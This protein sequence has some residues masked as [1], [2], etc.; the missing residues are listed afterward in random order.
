MANPDG[1]MADGSKRFKLNGGRADG[2]TVR[3]FP[4]NDGWDVL[5][6]YGETYLAPS[7]NDMK[8]PYMNVKA[9]IT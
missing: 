6:L 2:M 9:T 5:D 3:L 4:Q 7:P 1:S 8:K